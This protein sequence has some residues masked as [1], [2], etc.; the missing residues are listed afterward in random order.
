MNIKRLQFWSETDRV[1]PKIEQNPGVK[2]YNNEVPTFNSRRLYIHHSTDTRRRLQLYGP[3]ARSS[4][5]IKHNNMGE[6][7]LKKR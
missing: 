5:I 4:T 7:E 1:S 6:K 2:P 3:Y